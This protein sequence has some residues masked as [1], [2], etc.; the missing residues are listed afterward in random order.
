MR[1][2]VDAFI[3]LFECVVWAAIILAFLAIWS[4]P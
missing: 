4:V 3:D 2:M 1:G